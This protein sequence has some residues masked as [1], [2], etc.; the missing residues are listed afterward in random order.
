VLRRAGARHFLIPDLFNVACC[1]W[2]GQ[3]GLCQRGQHGYHAFLDE[4]LA[5]RALL[6]GIKILRLN[7]YR[8]YSAIQ[9]D[10]GHFGFT[11]VTCPA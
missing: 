2:P 6:K 8:L 10:T 9:A 5:A 11:N 4:L 1:P 7:V 3:C